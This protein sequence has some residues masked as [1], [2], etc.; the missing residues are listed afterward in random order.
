MIHLLAATYSEKAVIVSTEVVLVE[1]E[2][3]LSTLVLT[4]YNRVP[5]DVDILDLTVWQKD[6]AGRISDGTVTLNDGSGDVS[7]QL[8]EDANVFKSGHDFTTYTFDDNEAGFQIRLHAKAFPVNVDSFG[9]KKL[10]ATLAVEYEA[11]EGL[12]RRRLLSMTKETDV[13][14]RAEFRLDS[15]KPALGR[16]VGEVATM[17]MELGFMKSMIT[18]KN[19]RG[20][21]QG[22]EEALISSLKTEAT[23]R[24]YDG[25]VVVEAVYSKGSMIWSRPTAGSLNVNR[26]KLMSGEQDL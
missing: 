15:W 11:L 24:L 19:V 25:Q 21:V 3:D 8:M 16:G 2:Q 26:R 20:F 14:T 22:F 9:R 23:G 5:Y 7:V 18:R 13:R 6:G 17:S 4:G 1:L 10:L 12:T